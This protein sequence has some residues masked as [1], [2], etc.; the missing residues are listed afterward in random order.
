MKNTFSRR[1]G[2]VIMVA[3]LAAAM[4]CA[5]VNASTG[6]GVESSV[7]A[8]PAAMDAAIV[9]QTVERFMKVR[10]P[11]RPS[12]DAAGNLYVVDFPDGTNQLYRLAPGSVAGD[13]AAKMTKVS[14]FKDGISGYSIAPD[15][16]TIVMSAGEGGNENTS[17]YLLGEG[18][19]TTPLVGSAKVVTSLQQ[20]ADD[21]KGFYYSAND[22]SPSD[23]HLSYFDI[24]SRKPTK[25]LAMEGSW[26]VGDVTPDGKKMLVQRFFSASDGR[27]YEVDIS[28]KSADPAKRSVNEITVKGAGDGAT[29]DCDIVGYMPGNKGVLLLSD[30]DGQKKLYLRG[31]DGKVTKPISSLEAFE[32]ESAS[33]N[34]ER[35]LLIVN[36]NEDGY[37]VVHAY[38]LPTFTEVVLPQIEK[39][40]VS[41]ASLRAGTLVY[42]VSSARSPGISYATKLMKE[43]EKGVPKAYA[44]TKAQDQGLNF[45]AFPEPKLI[46]YRSF[47]GTEI[48]A[49]L[50]LPPD[51][52]P[53]TAIPFIVQYHGGPEGQ[54]RPQFDRTVQC[55]SK[56]GF[57]ILQPNVRGSTGYGRAFHMMD[58]YKKRWDSVRDGVD[59][60][61]WL[62]TSGYAKPGKIATYGGSYGGFMSVACL[63]ED[64][65]RLERGESKERLFGGG[66]NVVGIVN[67]KTFLEQTS[68]YRRKLREAEYG[69]LSDPEFLASVSSINRID[70]IKVPMM[71]AHGLN[72]PRVPVGEAMQLA[73]GLQARGF[74]PELFFAHDE[75]HGFAKLGNRTVFTERLARFM[76]RTI[77]PG[78]N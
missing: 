39:G 10:A 25:L 46:K 29:A 18:D 9:K 72:D 2:S 62:V 53:G 77:G 32:I 40:V 51:V 26:S 8:A 37:G 47:D 27:V 54:W 22:S 61:K 58:D 52:A 56:L 36:T 66:C 4:S 41:P 28:D 64:Q 30:M 12:F 20:F 49:F 13:P 6:S 50:Y 43:G 15:G 67:M 35:D 31:S 1:L 78:M 7:L 74:D 57:G 55:L 42:T 11:S 60:A 14:S 21:S 70:K 3:G 75:G 5:P 19:A 16:K 24:A 44:V 71:I 48:P 23:F 17:L 73:V 33:I 65:E 34:H 38:Y 69:P 76:L 63:V 68:G 45:A 59:A